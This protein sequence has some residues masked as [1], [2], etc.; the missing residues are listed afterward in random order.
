[1]VI[2]ACRCSDGFGVNHSHLYEWHSI[3]R[4][5]TAERV[6]IGWVRIWVDWRDA[7]RELTR[8]PSR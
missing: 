6:D 5:R 1:M 2:E 7:Y 8:E 4:P 3:D